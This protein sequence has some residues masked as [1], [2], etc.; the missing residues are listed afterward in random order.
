MLLLY[1]IF[2]VKNFR[3]SA[4]KQIALEMLGSNLHTKYL[5]QIIYVIC[6]DLHCRQYRLKFVKCLKQIV[7]IQYSRIGC[8]A[9]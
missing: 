9:G 5:K 4:S 1:S 2:Q 3:L 6:D 7:C 8:S